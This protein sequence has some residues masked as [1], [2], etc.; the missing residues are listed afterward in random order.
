VFEGNPDLESA[1]HAVENARAQIA[2]AKVFPDPQLTAGITQYD[3]TRQGNPTSIGAQL[4]VP[5]ELGGKRPARIA[6][7]KAEHDVAQADFKDV[8]RALGAMAADAFIEVLHTTAVLAQKRATL[9]SLLRLVSVN[10]RRLSAGDIAEA[11]LMQSRVEAEQ[12]RAEVLNAEGEVDAANVLLRQLLGER[13]NGAF[14]GVKVVGD[15]TTAGSSPQLAVLLRSLGERPDVRAADLRVRSTELQVKSE[16]AKRVIDI[17]ANVS[18]QHNFPVSGSARL[19]AADL[20]GLSLSLPLPFS[21]MYRGEVESAEAIH[22]QA[23]SQ[24][25]AIRVRAEGEVRQAL[26]RFSAASRRVALFEQG[27]LTNADAVLDKTLYNY[28]RGGTTLIEVL[29]AQR[30]DSDVHLAFLDA[31]AA[32]AHALVAVEQTAGLTNLLTL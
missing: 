22:L 28:E 26:A 2:V 29:L 15:L 24:L 25:S 5:L 10:E 14:S 27:V 7:A 11:L 1:R 12:F 19:N 13:S 4:S 23:Q 3:T 17:S 21:R 32:R 30:T 9:D 16:E 20:V 31:L 8:R 18:W 6:A